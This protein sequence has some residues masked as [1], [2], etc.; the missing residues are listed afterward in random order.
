MEQFDEAATLMERAL[1]LNPNRTGFALTLAAAYAHLGRNQ[2]ARSALEIHT[3]PWLNTADLQR[4]MYYYPFKNLA[5]ADRLA[6]GLLKAGLPGEPS[7]YYKVLEKNRLT[8]EEIRDLFFGHTQRG[9][10]AGKQPWA[11]SRTRD[12]EAAL[13]LDSKVIANGKSWIEEDMLC[14][15]W[16]KRFEGLKYY[17]SVF[18]NPKGTPEEKNEYIQLTD[19]TM[20]GVSIED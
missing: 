12:G 2:E 17:I 8:G 5:D 13:V 11:I 3:K 9:L 10:W 14:H 19:W 7:G 1:K 6:N 15:Q 16:E 20:Y 18:Q 4:V